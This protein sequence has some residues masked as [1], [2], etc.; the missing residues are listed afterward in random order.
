M[1]ELE[2]ELAEATDLDARWAAWNPG[3]ADARFGMI[4]RL[5]QR[6]RDRVAALF[7]RTEYQAQTGTWA[8]PTGELVNGRVVVVFNS[9]QQN[10]TRLYVCSNG[11]WR[12]ILLT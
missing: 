9:T 4:L 6:V 7:G 3:L 5:L 8:N 10:R 2:D 11:A 12:Y 1:A